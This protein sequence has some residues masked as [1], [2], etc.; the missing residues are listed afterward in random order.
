STYATWW[1]R[2]AI[3]RALADQS[4]LIRIPVHMVETM[5][6]YARVSAQLQQELG[7]EVTPEEVCAAMGLPPDR[8]QEVASVIRRARDPVSLETATGGDRDTSLADFIEDPEAPAPDQ[9]AT[10]SAF[11]E[12][13]Q[14]ALNSLTPRERAV[15]EMRFGLG[16]DAPRTLEEIGRILGVTRERIRQVEAGAMRKLRQRRSRHLRNFID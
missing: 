12:Q 11:R 9:V 15:I 5:H 2:Q 4:R 10:F 7:R 6:R 3:S 16:S 13:L 1:I 14:K 8:Y